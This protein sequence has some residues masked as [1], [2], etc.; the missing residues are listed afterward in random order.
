MKQTHTLYKFEDFTL[1]CKERVLYRGDKILTLAP[2][3][4]DTL[5]VLVES[6]GRIVSKDD[7]MDRIWQDSIV[8][9]SNLTQNIYT[10]RRTFGKRNKFIE[11]VPRRGYRFAA[12]VCRIENG[13][14]FSPDKIRDKSNGSS[15]ISEIV[16]ARKTKTTVLEEEVI[17]D[18]ES[19][20]PEK[21]KTKL[22]PATVDAKPRFLRSKRFRLGLF[23]GIFIA[24]LFSAVGFYLWQKSFPQ[25]V[26]A[27]VGNVVLKK[28]TDSGDVVSMS[29][30][31]DGQFLATVRKKS[32]SK[33]EIHLTDIEN[34]QDLPIDLSKD[35]DPQTVVFSADG[36]SIYFQN[37]RAN[38]RGSEIYKTSRFGGAAAL[39]AVDV[40]S[41]FS[42]SKSGDEIAFYRRRGN[43]NEHD[44]IVT[45]LAD[46]SEKVILTKHFPVGFD[47]RTAPE[48]SP[49]GQTIYAVL[50]PSGKP[51]GQLIKIDRETAQETAIEIPEARQ[52]ASVAAM[53]NGAEL[54]VALREEDKFPQIYKVKTSGGKL[55][56]LTNDLSV[57]RKISLSADGRRLAVQ[58]KNTFSHI[59]LV[60]EI[61]AGQAMQ[62]TSG[63]ANRDG[64]HGVDVLPDGRIVYTS[65]EDLNR[66]LW[67]V[68][69]IDGAKQQ[70]TRDRSEVNERPFVTG[71]GNYIYFN[72][73]GEKTYNIE[74]I[75]T[76]GR[77][78][79]KVTFNDSAD[80]SFPVVSPDGAKLY[81]IRRE[82]GRSTIQ[83]KIL[84]DGAETA[85]KLPEGF[86][87]EGFLAISPD[88]RFLAFRQTD[89]ERMS[90]VKEN[91]SYK[92]R[93]AVVPVDGE[94]SQSKMI[95]IE[96]SKSQF[97]WNKESDAIYFIRHTPR[98]SAIWKQKVF[99][100]VAPERIVELK[101]TEIYHFQF[102][103]AG[104][105]VVS[106]G[107]HR[108]DAILL[109]NFN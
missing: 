99:E 80:D 85:L 32:E 77:E 42:V 56:R 104:D 90:E 59:W 29:I 89:R 60:P 16:F 98:D 10:L 73:L 69:P 31:P 14:G 72:A 88:G 107:D 86:S 93:V 75:G 8:E 67:L 24:V 83:R 30:S 95:E 58:R 94:A 70:I 91:E 63:D 48:F 2:K 55:R 96:T 38:V 18:D 92:V 66:D 7:L 106:R 74:R 47:L 21:N 102:T 43:L 9:E 15:S 76:N 64:K 50:K 11:T 97:R 1:N 62:I 84:P 101:N 17:E 100:E 68:N 3:V 49:D 71:D 53:P 23:T 4:F 27:P 103:N 46:K 25:T 22:L 51:V 6:G 12:E 45:D 35:F 79:E 87:P 13:N 26:A 54:L 34:G 36:N 40:W 33:N 57:Y 5:C 81:F 44:L 65:L 52:F 20:D 19:T 41:D 105:L 28:L 109:T 78:R 39:S 82:K 37:H 108:D 61:D